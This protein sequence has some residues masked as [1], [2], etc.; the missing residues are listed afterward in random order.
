M[1]GI[2][3][4]RAVAEIRDRLD[5]RP[6]LLAGMVGSNR[7]WHEAPYVDCPAVVDGLA[8]AVLWIEPD[9][10]GI[11]PGV[12][13]RGSHADVMRG[14][15]MQAIGAASA[16]L[17]AADALLCHPGTHSKWVS[18]RDGAIQSFRTLMTGELF[19]LLK[20]HSILADR[21][22]GDVVD[23][24]SFRAS[25]RS[26][27]AGANP[28][29]GLFGIRAKAL[30]GENTLD[31]ASSVSGALIGAELRIALS[32]HPAGPVAVVGGA[33]LCALYASALAE[34]GRPAHVVDGAQAFL[35][36]IA[37]LVEQLK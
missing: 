33:G 5:D 1:D 15:E 34:A 26:A 21:L 7:G 8:R 3:F 36:G 4:A 2:G 37:A 23:D 16:G 20:G 29:S 31:A 28:I 12:C 35:A 13:Q 24:A 6:M 30:L 32:A 18:L 10:T 11:V 25:V 22:Q 9:R 19:S 27:L 14:E 17:V